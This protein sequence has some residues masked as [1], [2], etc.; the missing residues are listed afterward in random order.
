MTSQSN[1]IPLT[2]Q[3]QNTLL[4]MVLAL[5]F[6]GLMSIPF[7]NNDYYFLTWIAFIPLLFAIENAS[8]KKVYGI[9]VIGGFFLFVLGTFWIYGY[10]INAKG[11]TS[12]TSLFLSMAMWFLSAQIIACGMLVFKFLSR[13]TQVHEFILFPLVISFFIAVVPTLFSFHLGESQVSNFYALQAIAFVGVHGLD[14]IIALVNIVIFRMVFNLSKQ[15]SILHGLSK[16]SLCVAMSII[17]V[18][19]L[20]GLI[21]YHSYSK[22]IDNWPTIKLGL[23]Q[24]NEISSIERTE[25]YANYSQGYPPEMEMSSRLKDLGAELIVWPEGKTKGYLNNN[26]VKHAY[27]NTVNNLNVDLLFQDKQTIAESAYSVQLASKAVLLTKDGE[28]QGAYQKIKRIPFGEYLPIVENSPTLQ[29]KVLSWI[30]KSDNEL[31]AG[32]QYQLFRQASVN[33]IPLI[34]YETTDSSFVATAVKS[35]SDQ[36][37]KNH[38]S[39]LVALSNDGWFKSLEQTKLHVYPSALRAVE[40]RLPLVHVVNNGPSIVV[41]PTGKRLFVSDYQQAGG[42]LIDVPYADDFGASFYSK[43]PKLF[44]YLLYLVFLLVF[45]KSLIHKLK[46]KIK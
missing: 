14:V 24:P 39:L 7:L 8:L 42:Y 28:E 18:W 29:S 40:N 20:Y 12:S 37:D 2:S 23:I 36:A 10:G 25:N 11:L 19:F 46:R 21:S 5:L 41:A 30:G 26:K 4:A 44:V 16:L 43:Y 31:I 1:K 27:S 15:H 32:N 45:L 22:Q 38:G 3:K 34:C 9:S 13:S 17:G 35:T 6:S 33:I